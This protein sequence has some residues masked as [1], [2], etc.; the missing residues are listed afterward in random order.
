MLKVKGD[1]YKKM[2]QVR[3]NISKFKRYI[4]ELEAYSRCVKQQTINGGV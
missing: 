4:L 1:F 2:L 3:K